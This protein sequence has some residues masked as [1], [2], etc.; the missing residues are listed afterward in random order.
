MMKIGIEHE[1]VFKN[2]NGDY[3]DFANTE[4]ALFQKVITN[5]PYVENDERY[6]ECKSLE[7]KPKR[8]Y[9][10]G[11]ERYDEKGNITTTIPK[12]LEIRT[13]PH[14]SCEALMEEF[15]V[16]YRHMKNLAEEVGLSPL[17]VCWHPFK[18]TV[19]FDKPLSLTERKK[20]TQDAEDRAMHSML[21]SGMHFNV[22]VASF[23]FEQMQQLLYKINYYAPFIIPY[24]FSSPFS[25]SM[26]FCLSNRN[27]HLYIERWPI[28]Y[29]T[30]RKNSAIIEFRGFDACG[31]AKLLKALLLLFKALVADTT[32]QGSRK[33]PDKKLLTASVCDGFDDP[34]IKNEGKFLLNVLQKRIADKEA[35]QLLRAILENNDS[36]AKRMWKEYERTGDVMQVIS[37]QYQY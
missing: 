14:T 2:A 36:Y 6:F 29:A 19:A 21:S 20:R 23:S 18:D 22:S 4:Y 16:S 17:L 7:S 8:C 3:L 15:T 13:R 35:V 5:F 24:S 34:V 10:E 12:G 27:Y 33:S 1:F 30:R 37:E 26:S 31:D 11:F 25:K 32:L 28:A 9:V